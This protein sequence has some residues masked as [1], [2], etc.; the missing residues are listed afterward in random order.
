MKKP[1]KFKDFG[2]IDFE[3][4]EIEEIEEIYD[5]INKNVDEMEENA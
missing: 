2:Q 1:L 3:D 4:H 5:K